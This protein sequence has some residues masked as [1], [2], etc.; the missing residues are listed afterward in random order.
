MYEPNE[1]PRRRKQY[2]AA[3]IVVTAAITIIL[4][5]FVLESAHALDL[6]IEVVDGTDSDD[7]HRISMLTVQ[8]S[9]TGEQP[10]TPRFTALHD[11][12]QTV[13]YWQI[14]EGN[15]L[16]QPGESA[17]YRLRAPTAA[18][19]VPYSS[20]AVVA[21][22]DA[23]TERRQTTTVRFDRRAEIG[24]RNPEFRYWEKNPDSRFFQPFRWHTAMSTPGSETVEVEEDDGNAAISVADVTRDEGPWAMVGL[25]QESR[26]P[27]SITVN[28]T[29]G[30]VVSEPS[31]HPPAATG[32]EIADGDKRVW[33]VFA[34]IEDRERYYRGGETSYVYVYIPAT[35]GERTEATV[36]IVE[37]YERQ[38]WRRPDPQRMTID[39]TTYRA[40][41]VNVLAFSA[42]YPATS[43]QRAAIEFHS[44]SAEPL[45]D[46]EDTVASRDR[47]L[48]GS[49]RMSKQ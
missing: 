19:A 15:E 16:L 27:A 43:P 30:T 21:V 20:A 7:I 41:T 2:L 47:S 9:N 48:R 40:R 33:I 8:V 39:E 44:V 25:Q 49:D 37:I 1:L 23:G 13:S 12:H 24:I 46:D 42:V 34:D 10:L 26:F 35:A 6:Q 5:G 29:P 14:L 36:D 28:A 45:A 18:A 17:T 32:I 11:G 38:G 4:A 22:S 3:G 31:P